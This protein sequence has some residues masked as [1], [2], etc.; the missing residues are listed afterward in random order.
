MMA[1]QYSYRSLET[2]AATSARMKVLNVDPEFKAKLKAAASAHMADPEFR[3]LD[4]PLF[5]IIAWL[6]F[7]AFARF[8]FGAP[9]P[10]EDEE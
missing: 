9:Q 10:D 7:I 5:C 8:L 1:R 2:R 4:T 3:G 6:L